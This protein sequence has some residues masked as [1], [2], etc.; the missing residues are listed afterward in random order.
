M[1]HN[2]MSFRI[3]ENYYVIEFSNG[4]SR[5]FVLPDHQGKKGI[6][7]V[8]DDAVE[9]AINNGATIPGQV[10]AV[11]KGLTEKGYYITHP[12]GLLF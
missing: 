8:A 7:K 2:K 4:I 1:A 12:R 3:E 10:N 5:K 11:R 6:K 9:F